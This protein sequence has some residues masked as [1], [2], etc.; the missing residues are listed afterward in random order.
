ML[1]A[2]RWTL[3]REM[4]DEKLNSWAKKLLDRAKVTLEIFGKE[5]AESSAPPFIVISNHQSLYDIPILFASLPLSLRMAAKKELFSVPIWGDAMKVAGFVEIDRKNRDRARE[6]LMKAGQEMK[7]QGV[8][9]MVAPEGTR[10]RSHDLLPFKNGAF[11][12]SMVT[13]FP[14]LPVAINGAVRVHRSGEWVVHRDRTV[15][16]QILAPLFPKEYESLDAYREAGRRVIEEA[17][18]LSRTTADAKKAAAIL[19]E[20]G[21]AR[22]RAQED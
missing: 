9:L 13:G 8:S 10:S 20:E 3:T 7:E 16:V 21:E 17:L 5:S 19:D 18:V 6:A 2:R 12:L 14:I 11:R 4:C 15:K 1:H 22:V